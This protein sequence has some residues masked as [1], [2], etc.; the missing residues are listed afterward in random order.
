VA[1]H[2]EHPPLAALDAGQALALV[3]GFWPAEGEA[4]QYFTAHLPRYR[5]TM[6][7]IGH[8]RD[9]RIR[10]LELGSSFPYAFSILLSRQFP[11]ARVSLAQFDEDFRE[12]DLQ[13]THGETGETLCFHV[14]SFNCES[15]RWPFEDG[16]FDVVLCMEILE[17]LLLDPL[18][19]MR[20]AHRVLG[21][22]G[23]LV[24]TTPNLASVESLQKLMDFESPYRFG[25]Y[26]RHG[27]YGRHNREY[28]PAEV[29]QLGEV[30]GFSTDFLATRDVYADTCDTA[31]IKAALG[32]IAVNDM[33]RQN[34][35]YRGLKQDRP[36]AAYPPSLFDFDP[37]M[38]AAEVFPTL[39]ADSLKAGDP[40][41]GEARLRNAG[42]YTWQNHGADATTLRLVL[43]D[44]AGAVI[45]R[46][47][48]SVPLPGPVAPA[49][50]VGVS[51]SLP[52]IDEPGKYRLRFDMVHEQV[53]W[54][55]DLGATTPEIAV[56]VL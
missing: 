36:M 35:F 20:E 5:E 54:F 53:C 49:Q 28:V 4:R 18:H 39:N 33:R 44:D 9:A 17:H 23:Q 46:D 13:L 29:R 56:S 11:H 45:A 31:P 34:I 41:V 37:S 10:I 25:V 15:G 32:D 43:L 12:R 16:S 27:A 40:I 48:R 24:L 19:M 47:F 22:D 14:D 42:A 3:A 8:G 52:G 26:S 38:H 21:T 30:A 50:D 7:L 2:G 6:E 51:F 55:S 1:E